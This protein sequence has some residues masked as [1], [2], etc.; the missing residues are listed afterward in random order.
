M[1]QLGLFDPIEGQPFTHYNWSHVG[2]ADHKKLA[3]DGARQSMCLLQN[4]SMTKGGAA[5]PILP[6]KQGSKLLIAGP[7]TNAT[8]LFLG[9]Y[10]GNACAHGGDCLPSLSQWI[11]HF[12]RGGDGTDTDSISGV[13]SSWSGSTANTTIVI[14]GVKDACTNDTSKIDAAVAAVTT[15]GIDGSTPWC[16]LSVATAMRARARIE[17]SS[18]Y[19][20]RKHSSLTRLRQPQRPQVYLW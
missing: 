20:G 13:G 14:P 2:T 5:A 12:N 6:L 17:T 7:N 1:F 4:P 18:A 19:Q 10:N 16:S 3:L 9:N 8:T 11:E 15:G